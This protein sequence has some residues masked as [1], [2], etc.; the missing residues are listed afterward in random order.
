MDEDR[1]EEVRAIALKMTKQMDGHDM[2]IV[3]HALIMVLIYASLRLSERHR[4]Q[5]HPQGFV[6]GKDDEE[7]KLS[8]LAS[9]SLHCAG[10]IEGGF[11]AYKATRS[12]MH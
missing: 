5:E 7:I 8:V 11:D 3:G 1:L 12:A 4:C 6:I 2:A 9:I 10:A